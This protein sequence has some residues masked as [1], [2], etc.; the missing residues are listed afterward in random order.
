MI[1]NLDTEMLVSGSLGQALN[2]T[3]RTSAHA[4]RTNLE[5]FCYVQ[6]FFV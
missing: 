4:L 2:Y 6:Q 3:N 1:S 5:S